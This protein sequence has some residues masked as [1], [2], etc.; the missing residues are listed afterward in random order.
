MS[1]ERGPP[2]AE[3]VTRRL[4]AVL[5]ALDV[6]QPGQAMGYA[7]RA[8]ELATELSDPAL[9]ARSHVSVA[10]IYSDSYDLANAEH[11]F[12]LA[13]TLALTPPT[14]SPCPI[15]AFWRG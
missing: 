6:G 14:P 12:G 3:W 15:P 8:L 9:Q 2:E 5:A 11:H 13:R 10:L 7:L 1:A 4:D